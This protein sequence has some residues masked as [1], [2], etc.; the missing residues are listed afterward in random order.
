MS[1]LLCLCG[2]LGP[3]LRGSINGE[4][5][6]GTK[7]RCSDCFSR[8]RHAHQALVEYPVPRYP[9]SILGLRTT[10]RSTTST[11]I[12]G[13][14]TPHNHSSYGCFRKLGVLEGVVL[15]RALLFGVGIKTPDFGNSHLERGAVL[16]VSTQVPTLPLEVSPGMTA[17]QGPTNSKT[18][19][20]GGILNRISDRTPLIWLR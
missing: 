7:W 16:V 17:P 8:C 20:V 9:R 14:G 19:C 1:D 4:L 3:W 18:V 13:P 2:L 5:S 11:F 15:L 6:S 12:K 10:A